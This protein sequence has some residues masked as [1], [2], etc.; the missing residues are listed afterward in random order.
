[1][2]GI[3]EP[4]F[5]FRHAISKLD[6]CVVF[7]AHEL[8]DSLHLRIDGKVAMEDIGH[9]SLTSIDDAEC[10]GNAEKIIHMYWQ[11]NRLPCASSVGS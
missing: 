1:M 10:D 11:A 6:P 4:T 8:E 9:V 7:N 3:A 5:E 2:F